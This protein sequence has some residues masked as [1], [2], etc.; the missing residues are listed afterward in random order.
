MTRPEKTLQAVRLGQGSIR[1]R[2]LQILLLKLGFELVR[3]SGSHHIYL[4]PA[5]PRP[6][7]V[8]RSGKEAKPYQL[9]QL[10][11]IIEEFGLTLED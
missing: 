5:V 10:R 9:R 2:E 3:I 8:Q 7:N 6:M 11:D 4:H 1:F